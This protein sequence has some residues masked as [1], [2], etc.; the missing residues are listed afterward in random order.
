M[1]TDLEITSRLSRPAVMERLAA[2]GKEWRESKLPESIRRRG[3]FGC[4]ITV[5]GDTF[6][7][8]LEPQGRG[9]YLAWHGTVVSGQ[10]DHG[11]TI[12][13][14]WKLTTINILGYALFFVFL[15]WIYRDVGIAV[16]LVMAAF[17]IGVAVLSASWQAGQQAPLCYD[18]LD[19]VV[20]RATDT[21]PPAI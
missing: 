6:D 2:F 1:G 18:I 19:H 7:L 17:M 4:A 14:S 21:S 10:A 13:V 3:I 9:P 5:S 8:K 15:I 12:R 11:A 20:G 16:T